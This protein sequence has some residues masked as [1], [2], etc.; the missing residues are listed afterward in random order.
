M[1]NCGERK[2][3]EGM[4]KDGTSSELDDFGTEKGGL[5]KWP[6]RASE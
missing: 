6:D 3:V 1:V 4:E 5:V 2:S